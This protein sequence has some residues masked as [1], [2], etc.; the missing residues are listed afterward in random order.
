MANRAGTAPALF[1]MRERLMLLITGLGNPEAK[2]AGN[3]HNAG[4]MAVDEI[5]DFHGFGPERQKFSALI[6]EGVLTGPAGRVK[7]L[8]LKPQ[9]FYNDSGKAVQAAA[10][11]YKI[12]LENIIV[13]HDE[14]DLAPGK[15]KVKNGGGAAGNNGLKSISAHLGPDF[16]RV[17]IGIGHPGDKSR[18]TN[19]VLSDFS[20]A[21]RQDWADELIRAIA[22]EFGHFAAPDAEAKFL[23]ALALRLASAGKD[24][25]RTKPAPGAK[26]ERPEERNVTETAET[27]ENG[28][29]NGG[30]FSMLRGLFDRKDK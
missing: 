18:V 25:R 16:R 20:K 6:R 13:L 12:P 29:E 17:R 9:T 11:F 21:E 2:Y 4:F 8:I 3:R 5:A 30:A 23:S 27:E 14:L 15:V 19:Y 1:H 10:K 7:A 24:R 22:A 26:K 28:T